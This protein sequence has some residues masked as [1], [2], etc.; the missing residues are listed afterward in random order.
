MATDINE[1][2]GT[3]R[4]LMN[5]VATCLEALDYSGTDYTFDRIAS[6]ERELAE[7]KDRMSHLEASR[8]APPDVPAR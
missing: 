6:V 4:R 2:Q 8:Q 3:F 5:K 1:R 7:I